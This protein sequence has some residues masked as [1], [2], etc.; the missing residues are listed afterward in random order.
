M[1]STR[2]AQNDQSSLS[3]SGW[4]E[5]KEFLEVANKGQIKRLATEPN[6]ERLH[7]LINGKCEIG[8]FLSDAKW[9]AVKGS[10]DA[11]DIANMPADAEV[12]VHSHPVHTM[13][14]K[15]EGAF[16]SPID[17]YV[18]RSDA[19]NVIVSEVGITSFEGIKGDTQIGAILK[20]ATSDN[21]EYRRKDI[22]KYLQFLDHNGAQYKIY[23]WDEAIA[24]KT[25][26]FLKGIGA[27]YERHIGKPITEL[28]IRMLL[29]MPS[30]TQDD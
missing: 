5:I 11:V 10:P 28:R 3:S 30:S 18:A 9:S 26:Q 1:P 22:E 4:G 2:T 16:P 6:I 15:G 12:I 23:P 19:E 8:L 27:E 7:S 17:F 20:E 29:K 24:E 21:R 14:K 25:R 13:D